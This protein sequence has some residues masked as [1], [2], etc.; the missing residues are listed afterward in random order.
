MNRGFAYYFNQA[1]K[2]S[3]TAMWKNKNFFQVLAFWFMKLIGSILFLGAVFSLASVRQA[4]LVYRYQRTEIPQCF[5]V[6]SRANSVWTILFAIVL[7][8]LIVLAGILVIGVL[9]GLLVLVGYFIADFIPSVDFA[10][11]MGIF[12]VPG[13]I[14][15][16]TFLFLIVLIFSPTAYVIESNPGIS[17]GEAITAC[18]R[19]M[20]QRGKA[21]YFLIQFVFNLIELAILA[22]LGAVLYLV[23]T[24]LGNV[25]YAN[26]VFAAV[27]LVCV[28][29]FFVTL[30][31]FALAKS[32]AINALFEDIVLEPVKAGKNGKGI[33]IKKFE[34]MNFDAQ[35]IGEALPQLFDETEEDSIPLP[36]SPVRKRR[37]KE[38]RR[39][40]RE[41]EEENTEKT[42]KIEIVEKSA[43]RAEPAGEPVTAPL[44]T[45]SVSDPAVETPK[46]EPETQALS[47]PESEPE[48]QVKPE[49]EPNDLPAV[50]IPAENEDDSDDDSAFWFDRTEMD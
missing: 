24:Q 17:A 49:P 44:Q 40:A 31:M 5:K 14:L 42:E 47:E 19:T 7:E 25:K 35:N 13:G 9:T 4:K 36:D 23:I 2:S 16:L 1:M 43:E 39:A 41:A 21:T 6:A 27:L 22:V 37:R 20:K 30:P 18:L 48:L 46:T 8:A 12:S 50:E 26:A 11:M 32:V 15:L 29:I 28:V 10:L 45:E 33:Y 3:A 38:A 34:G